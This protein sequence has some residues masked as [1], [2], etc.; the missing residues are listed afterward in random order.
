MSKTIASAAIKKLEEVRKSF[1]EFQW[2]EKHRDI[3]KAWVEI[4]RQKN[5]AFSQPNEWRAQV[6]DKI[7]MALENYKHGD[8]SAKRG[9]FYWVAGCNMRVT[10]HVMGGFKS[11]PAWPYEALDADV[12]VLVEG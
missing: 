10:C 3:Y 5:M 2:F 1:F 8:K 6:V 12:A 11:T 9:R 7:D 4:R